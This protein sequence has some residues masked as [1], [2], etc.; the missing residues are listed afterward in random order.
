MKKEKELYNSPFIE[1]DDIL[2]F[3]IRNNMSVMKSDYS[4]FDIAQI[5]RKVEDSEYNRKLDN[6]NK[7]QELLR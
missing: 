4:E 5:K 7:L 1:D 3:L 6:H 2:L